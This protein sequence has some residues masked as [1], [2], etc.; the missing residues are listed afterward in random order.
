[1]KPVYTKQQLEK[2]KRPQ[3]W[4]ICSQLSLPKYPA[5]AKC[6]EAILEKQPIQIEEPAPQ[7]ITTA[8]S[9]QTTVVYVNDIAIASIVYNDSDRGSYITHPWSVMIAG[10]EIHNTA[11]W[12]QAYSYITWHHKQNTLLDKSFDQ[13]TTT[14]WCELKSGEPPSD[15]DQI[16]VILEETEVDSL[17]DQHFGTLC[18]LW[19]STTLLGTFYRKLF[20]D[21]WVATPTD[22]LHPYHCQTEEDARYWLVFH[23]LKAATPVPTA[24]S[25]VAA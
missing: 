15:T 24:K 18:R 25:L 16:E 23:H 2:L 6:I 10:N 7:K 9:D 1:M 21:E 22:S 4:E 14:E 20:T 8:E 5:S 11:T 17:P 3:L 13:L 19:H 12:Q